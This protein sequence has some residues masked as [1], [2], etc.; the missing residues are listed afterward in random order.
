[1]R[2]LSPLRQL[3]ESKDTTGGDTEVAGVCLFGPAKEQWGT[4]R[5]GSLMGWP[6]RCSLRASGQALCSVPTPASLTLPQGLGVQ[7]QRSGQGRAD[8]V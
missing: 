3:G 4:Q 1:M 8:E 5:W 7:M 6:A 2:S